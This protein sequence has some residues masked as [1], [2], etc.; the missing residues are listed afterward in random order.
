MSKERTVEAMN[1][2]H[3]TLDEVDDL[4][5]A[6]IADKRWPELRRKSWRTDDESAELGR[7]DRFFEAVCLE[8][9]RQRPSRWLALPHVP[10]SMEIEW[11]PDY[12]R[13]P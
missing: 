8:W 5:K 11:A 10:P 1:L 4:K 7:L 12:V 3:L 6:V 2:S 9:S 13:R